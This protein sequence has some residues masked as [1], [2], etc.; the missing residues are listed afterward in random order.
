M[1]IEQTAAYDAV[2]NGENIFLTGP[3]GVGKSY[4]INKIIQSSRLCQK[5]VAVTSMTG[6]SASE[7]DGVTIHSYLGLRN[8]ED[9]AEIMIGRILISQI[10]KRRWQCVDLL[11]IDEISMMSLDLFEKI[12]S[13]ARHVR[14]DERFFGGIQVLF[15]GDFLQLKPVKSDNFC[16]ESPRWQLRTIE[17]TISQRQNDKIF[18]NVLNKIRKCEIDDE[19]KRLIESR[20]ISFEIIDG[21]I[22][23]ALFAKNDKADK[24][25]RKYY[26]SINE[27]EYLYKIKY[28][29][30]KNVFNKEK[31]MNNCKFPD[32]VK[33]KIGAQVMFLVND[34]EAGLFN[35]SRGVVIGF[36]KDTPVV[37]FQN[38]KERIVST[39]SINIQE[40]G[41]TVMTYTQ[42]PLKLCWA[43][44][45]HKSQGT[46]LE[47]ARI[48][49]GGIFEYGQFYVALSRV[50]SLESLYLKNI[51][52]NL[53]KAHPKALEFY[54]NIGVKNTDDINNSINNTDNIDNNNKE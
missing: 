31:Y 30:H 9:S 44:S 1:N 40:K 38:G 17:L 45:I 18:V 21:I 6:I 41:S 16:F 14:N 50:K 32:E 35:G 23:T 46:T 22:P 37:L 53:V 25:N 4:V 27:K 33:L 42:I 3:G 8:G 2:L 12:E 48:D 28:Y 5:I 24:M 39:H 26:D 29:W 10:Y 52:W 43:I 15:S 36:I 20:E 47:C 19:C 34:N 49:F 7:I 11:I 13:I 54:H 51:N